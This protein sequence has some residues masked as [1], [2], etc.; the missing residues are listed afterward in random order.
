MTS[1]HADTNA[2]RATQPRFAD[3]A[4]RVTDMASTLRAALDAEGEC[5]GHDETGKHFASDYVTARDEA[6]QGTDGLATTFGGLADN[7][8][9]IADTLE[10][11]DQARAAATNA[12]EP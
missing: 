11:Q 3:V 5:W 12:L 9:T 10:A 4:R 2:L 6:L 1:L 8:R 7:V